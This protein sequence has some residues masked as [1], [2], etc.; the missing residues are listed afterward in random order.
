MIVT[1][2]YSTITNTFRVV[3]QFAELMVNLVVT[4]ET[5]EVSMLWYLW[6]VAQCYGGKSII[7]TTNGGQ[8]PQYLPAFCLSVC[9][10]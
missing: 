1:E 10:Y 4:A 2:D 6:Y 9:L 7:S 5:S 8:V 3:R